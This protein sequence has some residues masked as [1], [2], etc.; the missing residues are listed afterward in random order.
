MIEQVASAVQWARMFVSGAL[1]EG[2][3]AVDATA[4]N[5]QDTVFLARQVGDSGLVYAFDVQEQAIQNTAGRLQAAGL[6]NRVKLLQADHARLKEHVHRP[7]Q[8]VMFNLGYLPGGDRN[9]VTRPPTTGPALEQALSLLAPGGRMSVVVYT[10]HRGA[11]GEARLVA[12]I[13][14]GLEQ[15]DYLVLQLNYWNGPHDAPVI[16]LIARQV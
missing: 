15:K 12:A 14:A 11:G 16:Y 8:A 6:A 4:G 3:V 9:L 5:G 10:G 13:L 7:V 2:A 1:Y